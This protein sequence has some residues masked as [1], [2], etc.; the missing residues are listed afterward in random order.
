MDKSERRKVHE[1]AWKIIEFLKWEEGT[2][3]AEELF[4]EYSN[5]FFLIL[6]R[7]KPAGGY[8]SLEDIHD[9]FQYLRRGVIGSKL[10]V[11]QWTTEQT[12]SHINDTIFAEP[13]D[14]KF[15]FPVDWLEEFPTG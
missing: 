11:S 2:W 15:Y 10:D 3:G 14:Y 1:C 6:S 7:I 5:E 4:A 9:Y 8:F 13:S 12:R